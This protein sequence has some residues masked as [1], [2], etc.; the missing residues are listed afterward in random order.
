MTKEH[1]FA[2]YIR[3]LAGPQLSR[4]LTET[5]AFEAFGMVMAGA[6]ETVQLGAFLCLV[7][8]A[9]E[10]PEEV[11]GFVRAARRTLTLPAGPPKVDVDWPA[12]AGKKQRP[13]WFLL[14]ALLLAQN[15]VRVFM[16]GDD[17][18]TEGRL[19]AGVCLEALGVPVARSIDEAVR[20]LEEHNFAYLP[21]E[22]LSPRLHELIALKSVI[23][24][25]TPV[26]TIVRNLN[27]LGA[28]CPV[29]G[30]AHPPYRTL[31]Q[32]AGVMLGERFMAV[33]KGDGGEAER[34]PEKPCEVAMIDNGAPRS[35]TWPPQIAEAPPS[36]DQPSTPDRLADLW[37]G[38][39]ADPLGE[40]AVVGTAAVVLKSL[41]LVD[42]QDRALDTAARFWAQRRSPTRAH[43]H[44]GM[45]AASRPEVDEP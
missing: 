2:P 39:T 4:T 12:Y 43:R 1:P 28:R 13:P 6:V 32:T 7:R 24:L 23:G 5:E 40:A 42:D 34:R 22:R 29:V 9:A 14:A 3:I 44:P 36:R 20:R 33:F 37:H 18:H 11:I 10:T 16:H 25:R 31:H 45:S 26:H 27:P 17:D 35:E 30:V 15:G 41:R 21:L 38:A 8:E 19:F